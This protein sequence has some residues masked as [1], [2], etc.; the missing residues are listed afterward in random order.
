MFKKILTTVVLA[1]CL[2]CGATPTLADETLRGLTYSQLNT[3]YKEAVDAVSDT[4]SMYTNTAVHVRQMPSI[5][6]E[7]IT[8]YDMNTEVECLFDKDGWTTIMMENDDTYY[9]IKSDFLS[10]TMRTYTDSDLWWL[11]HVI[12]G[13]MQCESYDDQVYTGSVVLNRVNSPLWSP[14]HSLSEVITSRK[15]GIQYACYWDGNFHREPTATNWAVARY[16]LENG[17]Q[18]P[19]NVVYQSSRKQG[20]V[21]KHTSAAYYCY[22]EA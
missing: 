2:L 7:I 16:L 11:A 9:F 1:T 17:S 15:Y 18:L 8:T 4:Y 12:C 3:E 21:W 13:E 5:E 10:K 22:G 6:A 19:Y 14:N 20:K